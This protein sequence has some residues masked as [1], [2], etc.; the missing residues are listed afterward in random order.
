MQHLVQRDEQTLAQPLVLAVDDH[1]LEAR[2]VD[3]RLRQ[4]LEFVEMLR[5]QVQ[6]D[7][8]AEARLVEGEGVRAHGAVG[9]LADSSQSAWRR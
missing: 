7:G 8:G 2:A 6:V 1:E 5:L 9:P 3:Q 4:S